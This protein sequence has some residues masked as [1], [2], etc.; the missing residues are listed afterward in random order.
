MASP[1]APIELLERL[2]DGVLIAWCER[3]AESGYVGSVFPQIEC[4]LPGAPER[5][6]LP[7]IRRL[8]GQRAEPWAGFC[9]LFNYADTLA[10][11]EAATLLGDALCAALRQARVLIADVDAPARLRSMLRVMPFLGLWILG[12][13]PDAGADAAMVPAHTTMQLALLMPE[14]CRGNVLDLGCGPGTLALVAA[15]RG[16]NR[17]TGVD[18]NPRAIRMARVNTRLN[19]VSAQFVAGDLYAPVQGQRFDLVVSQPPYV[20]EPDAARSVVFMHA[21]PRGEELTL[22][23]L[24]G[25]PAALAPGGI[26]VLLADLP[27]PATGSLQAHLRN[28]LA[29]PACDLIVATTTA[30]PI[31]V[32]AF[33]YAQ[34]ADA[35][36]GE[37]YAASACRYLDHLRSLD[38]PGFRQAATL[39]RVPGAPT[40]ESAGGPTDP[41]TE[42]PTERPAEWPSEGPRAIT[43]SFPVNGFGSAASRPLDLF[44]AAVDL[45][46]APAPTLRQSTLSLTRRARWAVEADAPVVDGDITWNV[47]FSPGALGADQSLPQASVAILHFVDSAG[48]VEAALTDYAEACDATVEE[49]ASQ[50][51]DFIRHA[52]RTGLLEPA[53]QLAE[54]ANGAHA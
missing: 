48:T 4:V 26:G 7:L 17:A 6:R 39:V 49:I 20:V 28:A 36:L 2:P 44:L 9:R 1:Q 29:S 38:P 43:A 42:R 16:A 25:L 53:T 10:D 19:G 40:G 35:T 18:I 46:A 41:P 27:L 45:A 11:G 33:A 23:A 13:P 14:Q 32:Q 21:G 54:P 22:R 15:Q 30:P 34:V 31:E 24:A 3:M 50:A 37:L 12:D 8:L 51:L 47:R 52:L 5:A